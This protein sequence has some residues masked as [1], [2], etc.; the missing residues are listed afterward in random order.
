MKLSYKTFYDKVLGCWMGKNIGGTLGAPVEFIRQINNFDFYTHDLNGEPLPNDDLDLQLIWLL[1]LE[2]CGINITARD[3]GEFW[4][5]YQTADWSE[6]GIC[7]TN[8]KSGFVPPVSGS[9][10][11][12]YKDSNGAFIR[13]EIWA[14]ICPGRPDLAAQYA[15][16]D[17]IVDHGDGEGTYAAI[18]CAAMES[19][20]FVESDFK[21]LINIGLSYIPKDC[22]VA[23]AILTAVECYDKKI[24]WKE[25]RDVILE[26]HRGSCSSRARTTI[27]DR[28]FEKGFHTGLLG[29]DV[30][31]N[32]AIIVA[33]MLYGEGDFDKTMC[34]T[35]NMGEDTDCTGATVGSIFGI[36]YGYS[37][38]PQRWIE[39]I[40]HTIN[41]I[42]C[43]MTNRPEIPKTVE[44]L[45]ERTI[46][47]AK[48]VSMF[49]GNKYRAN[50]KKMKTLEIGGDVDDVSDLDKK[51]LYSE[52]LESEHKAEVMRCVK[53][54]RYDAVNFSAAL[55]YDSYTLSPEGETKIT[56]MLAPKYWSIHSNLTVE[57]LSDDLY[58]EPQS[59]IHVPVYARSVRPV[60]KVEFTV[61]A[62]EPKPLYEATI[63]ISVDGRHTKLF[64][65]VQLAS[66]ERKI[67]DRI[68]EI[69]IY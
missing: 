9:L 62:V 58:V 1:C 19:A 32:I 38:I 51:Y 69:V 6:Y 52:N 13:S 61:S 21:E 35:V 26:K 40:G 12:E 18:F 2:E 33:G 64:I 15:Y 29:F 66:F 14:C 48:M 24:D 59:K 30:P 42:C 36:I 17:S 43:N 10:N 4:L 27:S 68:N 39:P 28:D 60:E 55:D 44:N 50:Y 11:N 7:K 3:L 49:Y 46:E 25:C 16:E 23:K 57:W 53:G 8:M 20:A 45:T 54:P 63:K 56:L 5:D 34:Q 67:D 22:E 47:Q 65:P 37:K 31:A 41:S